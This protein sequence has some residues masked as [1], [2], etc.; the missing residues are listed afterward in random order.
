MLLKSRLFLEGYFGKRKTLCRRIY[1]DLIKGEKDGHEYQR[2]YYNG[3]I[4][5]LVKEVHAGWW[6]WNK[7]Y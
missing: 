6:H 7:S 5:V 3:L 1:P 2:V 4:G